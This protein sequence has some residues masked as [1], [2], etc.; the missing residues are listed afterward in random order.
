MLLFFGVYFGIYSNLK[1]CWIYLFDYKKVFIIRD[2]YFEEIK[3]LMFIDINF[4]FSSGF[5]NEFYFFG[6]NY[7]WS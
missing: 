7:S 5:F 3:F 2:V 4:D 1:V 6:L